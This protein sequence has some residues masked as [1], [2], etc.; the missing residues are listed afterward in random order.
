MDPTRE[1]II[2]IY[3]REAAREAADPNYVSSHASVLA[4]TR[5]EVH[6]LLRQ[7]PDAVKAQAAE[8]PGMPGS[9]MQVAWGVTDRL[10]REAGLWDAA[11]AAAALLA[12]PAAG[13]ASGVSL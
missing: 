7:T 3:R 4:A 8:H 5:S 11:G 2:A 6:L 9:V 10:I 12:A 13:A 1:E